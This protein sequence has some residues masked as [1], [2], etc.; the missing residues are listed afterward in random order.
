[1]SPSL[2]SW[3]A[4]SG[5]QQG[6]PDKGAMQGP[7]RGYRGTV[8][9]PKVC[10]SP[11]QVW[12]GPAW[13]LT[14]GERVELYPVLSNG[15]PLA[16]GH[17]TRNWALLAPVDA[18]QKNQVSCSRDCE[19]GG[20]IPTRQSAQE[21]STLRMVS[22]VGRKA[23]STEQAEG[24]SALHPA[25]TQG[26]SVTPVALLVCPPSHGHRSNSRELSRLTFISCQTRIN[27]LHSSLH[28]PLRF[29]LVIYDPENLQQ[30]FRGKPSTIGELAEE[31]ETLGNFPSVRARRNR[32]WL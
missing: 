27:K 28:G 11:C 15:Q 2:R 32:S 29:W 19:T 22:E 18:T 4:G 14:H 3:Q 6:L 9:G 13:S 23:G 10:T 5:P 31:G 8:A 21:R 1:M 26:P 24:V 16:T 25:P 30:V 12:A 20:Q 17:G 7:R